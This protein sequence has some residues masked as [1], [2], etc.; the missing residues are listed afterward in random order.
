MVKGE[1][2]RE[3]NF[4]GGQCTEW[5]GKEKEGSTGAG[6]IPFCLELKKSSNLT[7]HIT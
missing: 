6:K 3:M 7:A 5:G 1:R 2:E 4:R